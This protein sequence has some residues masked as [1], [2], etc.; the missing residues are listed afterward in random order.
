MFLNEPVATILR[1][2]GVDSERLSEKRTPRQRTP[3]RISCCRVLRRG[4]GKAKCGNPKYTTY[5]GKLWSRDTMHS[6]FPDVLGVPALSSQRLGSSM[7]SGASDVQ[8][9]EENPEKVKSWG[10]PEGSYSHKRKARVCRPIKERA[11]NN[12]LLTRTR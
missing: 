5:R 2:Q 12:Y 6:A 3:T 1:S 11:R 4:F 10:K 9:A 7:G 8:G